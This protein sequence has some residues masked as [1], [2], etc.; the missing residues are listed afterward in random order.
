[1][2][3]VLG[4]EATFAALQATSG[5]SEEETLDALDLLDSAGVLTAQGRIY[6]FVH[7]L[8]ATVVRTDLRPAR[9]A[10]LHRRAA[11]AI[12]R[13]YAP[14]SAQIAGLLMEHYAATGDLERAAD[15]A[16]Q[17]AE[18]AS[19]IGASIEA[20]AYARRALAW[21]PTPRRQLLL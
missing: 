9:G 10:F 6:Q 8:V 11:E 21:Q 2:A 3:A 20:P 1:A 5:R 16:E 12:E 18:H 17:A 14:H 15:Y 13:A 4:D 19:Q 7:P